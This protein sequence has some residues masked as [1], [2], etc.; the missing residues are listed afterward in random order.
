MS[1]DEKKMSAVDKLA[2]GRPR[3]RKKRRFNPARWFRETRS[4]IKKVVWP[5]SR[6]I[7]NNTFVVLVVMLVAAVVLW[8]FDSVASRGVELLVALAR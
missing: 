2:A 3:S 4:E 8:A 7:S 5:T 6:Q 1:N